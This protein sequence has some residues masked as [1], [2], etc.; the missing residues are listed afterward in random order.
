MQEQPEKKEKAF[1]LRPEE[2]ERVVSAKAAP[3]LT[4]PGMI[5]SRVSYGPEKILR[6]EKS[7]SVHLKM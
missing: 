3:D 5:L 7:I 4:W 2:M 6:S 1:G